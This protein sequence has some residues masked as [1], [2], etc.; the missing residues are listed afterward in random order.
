MAI[1][2]LQAKLD[3]I[4]NNLKGLK[5]KIDTKAK[6]AEQEARDHLAQVRKHIEQD[7]AKVSA[8]NA[9]VKTWFE[10]KKE[11]T[12]AKIDEWKSK[13]ETKQLQSRADRAERYAAAR[14][15]VAL[16]AIDD[17]EA[18]TLEAWLARQDAMS[19]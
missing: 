2:E 7:R 15:D 18:A 16:A 8:A 4:K 11:A 1:E 12:A 6:G 13:H 5:V 10:T 14:I 3:N 17:A 19:A 9:E